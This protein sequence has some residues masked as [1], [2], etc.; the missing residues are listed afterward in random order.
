MTNPTFAADKKL[1]LAAEKNSALVKKAKPLIDCAL[2]RMNQAYQILETPWKRAQ[3]W[4]EQGRFDGFFMA[5]QNKNRDS[6]AT[7]SHPLLF[8]EWLYVLRKDTLIQ[9]KDPE[10]SELTF[11]A[12]IG[13]ARLT[14]LTTRF[15]NKKIKYPAQGTSDPAKT[16]QMLLK[17]RY[18]VALENSA[19]WV[20]VLTNAGLDQSEFQTYTALTKPLAVYFSNIF[21]KANPDFL[22]EYNNSMKECISNKTL[23]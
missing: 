18:D 11:A 17:G 10:F 23:K 13:S 7:F 9:P 8:I 15:K 12:N 14:W 20:S 1:I 6:Y 4:T 3:I 19:N 21:L 16:L 22:G 2:K 5:S